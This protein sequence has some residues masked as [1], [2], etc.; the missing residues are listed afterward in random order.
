MPKSGH[1]CAP[2]G[3]INQR[4]AFAPAFS[5]VACG[6]RNMHCCM[7]AQ[8]LCNTTSI[9]CTGVC[10]P[11]DFPFILRH[12]LAWLNDSKTIRQAGAVVVGRVQG[13]VQGGHMHKAG[14]LALFLDGKPSEMCT[15]Q[16]ERGLP[17][18]RLLE[19]TLLGHQSLSV[20]CLPQIPGTR[21]MRVSKVLASHLVHA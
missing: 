8:Y 9:M 4:A 6:V 5:A 15:F 20:W 18:W 16:N 1:W 19:E 17:C 3:R 10:V 21:A 7:V 12:I 13:R 14:R 2:Q 11:P